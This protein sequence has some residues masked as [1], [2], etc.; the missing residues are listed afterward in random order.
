MKISLI[1]IGVYRAS[2]PSEIWMTLAETHVDIGRVQNGTVIY[3]TQTPRINVRLDYTSV[4]HTRSWTPRTVSSS[5]D[6]SIVSYDTSEPF[7]FYGHVGSNYTV[8]TPSVGNHIIQPTC[9]S[10]TVD[11]VALR[12]LRSR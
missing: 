12:Q 1:G 7:Y 9:T 4:P 5:Y 11:W 3:S 10:T 6:G 2:P 8:F